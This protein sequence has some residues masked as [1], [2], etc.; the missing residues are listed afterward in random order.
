MGIPKVCKTKLRKPRATFQTFT[1]FRGAVRGA[2]CLSACL[3]A[4][5]LS[6]RSFERALFRTAPPRRGRCCTSVGV[7]PFLNA[8]IVFVRSDGVSPTSLGYVL[9]KECRCISIACRQN[10]PVC[11][12]FALLSAWRTSVLFLFSEFSP[13]VPAH[14]RAGTAC[15]CVRAFV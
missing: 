8:R 1:S 15:L 9:R 13:F 4:C 14:V 3:K 2:T 7:A 11:R 6:F 10:R 12:R 5:A